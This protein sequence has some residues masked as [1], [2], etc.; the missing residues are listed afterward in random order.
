MKSK[1]MYIFF[2]INEDYFIFLE[3]F[4]GYV[5]FEVVDCR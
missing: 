2:F 1:C 5:F 4:V 3:I